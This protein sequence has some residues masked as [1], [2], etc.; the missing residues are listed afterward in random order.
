[1]REHLNT[2]DKK[3]THLDKQ[4]AGELAKAK[5]LLKT[6]KKGARARACR[7]R[8]YRRWLHCAALLLARITAHA[9]GLVRW[10]P[11]CNA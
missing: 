7:L 8:S 6:N 5:K 4:I 9:T 1:M 3:A 2:M 11:P 10:Q